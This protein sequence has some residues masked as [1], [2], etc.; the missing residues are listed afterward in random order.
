MG[1]GKVD[2]ATAEEKSTEMKVTLK[3]RK[4]RKEP[5][6]KSSDVRDATIDI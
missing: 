1:E 4:L 2:M 3:R 5:R 6:R